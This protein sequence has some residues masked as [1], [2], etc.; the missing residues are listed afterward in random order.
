MAFLFLLSPLYKGD[1][2]SSYKSHWPCGSYGPMQP[3]L[4]LRG[5]TPKPHDFKAMNLENSCEMLIF[6]ININS[7]FYC[8]HTKVLKSNVKQ[9]AAF[10]A[11]RERINFTLHPTITGQRGDMS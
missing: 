5:L 6:S 4:N 8:S 3:G 11:K 2:K 1:T 7:L 10:K 9:Q